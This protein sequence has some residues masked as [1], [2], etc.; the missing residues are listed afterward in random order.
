M[1]TDPGGCHEAPRAGGESKGARRG[2]KRKREDDA[3]AYADADAAEDATEDIPDDATET[4]ETNASGPTLVAANRGRRAPPG[5]L[6]THIA[7]LFGVEANAACFVTTF[8]E[9]RAAFVAFADAARAAS[10]LATHGAAGTLRPAG[11]PV[12]V[13]LRR[14]CVDLASR[15]KAASV[16]SGPPPGVW[17]PVPAPGPQYGEPSPKL[18]VGSIPAQY[19]G[20]EVRMIF[21]TVGTVR[22]VKI[23]RRADGS[24]KGSGF[25]TY[26]D[27][28]EAEPAMGAMAAARWRRRDGGAPRVPPAATVASA[29]VR[30]A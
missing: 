25:V 6:G 5:R 11:S 29:T 24:H 12:P 30:L 8:P 26:A 13:T 28:K 21:A 19:G 27:V 9:T 4:T 3:A 1:R 23:L 16:A 20:A 17:P 2:E 18:Y 7:R 10:A 15:P 22:E 14:V